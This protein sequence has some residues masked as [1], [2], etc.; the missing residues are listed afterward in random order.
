M[1]R[2]NQALAK[3]SGQAEK[4]GLIGAFVI[5]LLVFNAASPGRFL[6]WSNVSAVLGSQAV[7]VVL[8]LSLVITLATDMY[9]LSAASVLVFCNMLIAVLNVN[10]GVPIGWALLAAL[11]AGIAVGCVNSFF[12]IKIGLNSLIVTLGSRNDPQRTDTLDQ[13][14]SDHQRGFGPVSAPGGGLPIVRN[15]VR[16]LLRTHHLHCPLVCNGFHG[17][18]A[19]AFVCGAI[20]AG[21]PTHWNQSGKSAAKRAHFSRAVECLCWNPLLWDHRGSRSRFRTHLSTAWD[22]CRVLW[23]DQYRAGAIQSLG[24]DHCRLFSGLRNQR[25]DDSGSANVRAEPLLRRR[26]G[27]CRDAFPAGEKESVSFFGRTVFTRK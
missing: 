11:G 16:I 18:R 12:I 22:G 2:N 27:D 5:L 8:T 17:H 7:L 10:L 24:I 13:R 19:P 23:V 3:L 15:P 14:F 20:T 25:S 9:D 1:T 26:T 6:T 21:R 4:Y